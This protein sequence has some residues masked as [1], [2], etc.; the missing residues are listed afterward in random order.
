MT[1]SV[2]IQVGQ[3]GNQIG[4]QFW[5]LALQEHA[6]TNK[7]GLYNEAVSS[8]FR[9]VDSRTDCSIDTDTSRKIHTL[10]ARAVLVDM[11]EGVVSEL[12]RSPLGELFDHQQLITDVS[13]SGNNWAVGN[14]TYG[15]HYREA[16]LE[17][18]RRAAEFCD[19]LQCFFIIHSM[20][21]GTGAGVGTYILD[22]LNDEFPDVY[23]FVNALYPSA[24]DDVITSPYNSVLAM[25]QLTHKA[26]CVLPIENQALVDIVDKIGQ[27]V[28]CEKSGKR[29]YNSKILPNTA[30]CATNTKLSKLTKQK[31]FDSMNNIVANLILNM[32]S[33]SRFEGLLNVDL[34]ELATNLVPY[35]KLHYLVASQTPLYALADV[36]IAPRRL[37][38][39]F[40]DA[41]SKDHQLIKADPRHSLY[42][43]CALMVRG[44]VS[45]SDMRRN[46]E[47][48]KSKLQ[49]ISWNKE[50]WKTGL[51]SVPPVGH[52]YSLLTLANNTC[53]QQTFGD[54]RDRY[55]KLYRR[56][57]HLHHYTMVDGMELQEF[58]DSYNSLEDIIKE[59]SELEKQLENPGPCVPR[60]QVV[61]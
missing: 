37:D 44:K 33:S 48:L 51:C 61:S 2:I 16:I 13:G 8:F 15:H 6:R 29:T 47:R 30:I 4:R 7:K 18:V 39:M 25:H 55:M 50:G 20:G 24:D 52:P 35:P 58:T 9:N 27:A 14:K 12:L 22:L 28:P 26:D 57:A 60:L 54:L 23:R 59:Y 56:K 5:D 31:P 41:F 1:Q 19:C 40:S 17:S 53:I 32:T 36:N 38:Q 42:L 45:I 10:K 34:N 11:E 49:F 43:A 21:G 46:I 3:C